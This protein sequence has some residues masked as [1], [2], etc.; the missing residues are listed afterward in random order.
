MTRKTTGFIFMQYP[1][2]IIYNLSMIQRNRI[3]YFTKR[4]GE[5]VFTSGTPE[6]HPDSNLDPNEQAKNKIEEG[7]WN[8]MKVF[9]KAFCSEMTVF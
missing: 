1:H 2:Y 9:W 8:I 6:R 4:K 5:T 7:F 3:A